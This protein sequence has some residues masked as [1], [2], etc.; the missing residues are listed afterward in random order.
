V[1]GAGDT[2]FRKWSA[3]KILNIDCANRKVAIVA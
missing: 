3:A 1:I 2:L